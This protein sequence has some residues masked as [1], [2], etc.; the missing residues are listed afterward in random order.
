V[1]SAAVHTVVSPPTT[2][3]E[4]QLAAAFAAVFKLDGPTA[5]DLDAHFFQLGGDSLL[6]LRLV[7][8]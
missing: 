1:A 8:V 7:Q 3:T 2:E 4:L 5:I 6:C